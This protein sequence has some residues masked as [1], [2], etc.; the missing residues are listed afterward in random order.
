MSLLR[1]VNPESPGHVGYEDF[2]KFLCPSSL[3][4]SKLLKQ[5]P[6]KADPTAASNPKKPI[7]KPIVKKLEEKRRSKSPL[8]KKLI[9]SRISK[10]RSPS[11]RQSRAKASPARSKVSFGRKASPGYTSSTLRTKA[12][13]NTTV[14]HKPAENIIP[15]DLK[16]RDSP[17]RV[18]EL[19]NTR[20]HRNI[21]ELKNLFSPE[22]RGSSERSKN[23]QSLIQQQLEKRIPSVSKF[24]SKVQSQTH[25]YP[26]KRLQESE[27]A[28]DHGSRRQHAGKTWELEVDHNNLPTSAP[29]RRDFQKLNGHQSYFESDQHSTRPHK[30]SAAAEQGDASANPKAFKTLDQEASLASNKHFPQ[31]P[32]AKQDLVQSEYF[33]LADKPETSS[34]QGKSSRQDQTPFDSL[35][36]ANFE[37]TAG[38]NQGDFSSADRRNCKVI[39][40]VFKSII[41]FSEKMEEIKSLIFKD[42]TFDLLGLLSEVSGSKDIAKISFKSLQQFFLQLK[43]SFDSSD[44]VKFLSLVLKDPT[45][46]EKSV[47]SIADLEFILNPIDLDGNVLPCP[48]LDARFSSKNLGQRLFTRLQD[49][50]R[51]QMKMHEEIQTELSKVNYL[52]RRNLYQH[53]CLLSVSD[54]GITW[55]GI[56]ACLEHEQ[57]TFYAPDIIFLM[58]E[59]NTESNQLISENEF[60]RFF[61]LYCPN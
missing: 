45:L 13:P 59:F 28:Q 5:Y 14:N 54:A 9:E 34:Q 38:V 53:L 16:R 31:G 7:I 30:S 42:P 49:L 43:V 61:D 29:S 27:P 52:A 19:G 18:D 10:D 60:N 25:E 47:F 35:Q 20:R 44:F 24:D 17:A 2:V 1:R 56:S 8:Y 58:R 40:N 57:V 32:K 46:S 6:R 41:V 4:P 33:S 22:E 36:T 50:L 48:P 51:L 37:Y 39:A 55:E 12:S 3:N 26:P 15:N 11:S 21:Q 23:Q